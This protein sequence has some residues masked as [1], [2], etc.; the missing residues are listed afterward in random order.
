MSVEYLEKASA[1]TSSATVSSVRPTCTIT[2]VF[3]LFRG[4]QRDTRSRNSSRTH[5]SPY[6]TS[7]PAHQ[8]PNQKKIKLTVEQLQ[9]LQ[10]LG[11]GKDQIYVEYYAQLRV[12][13]FWKIKPK[14]HQSMNF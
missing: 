13:Q 11:S 5:T 10:H 14:N 1:P 7:G 8:L 3:S 9:P 12:L 4:L 6:G 2:S